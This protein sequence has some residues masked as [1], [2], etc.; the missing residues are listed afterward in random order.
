MSLQESHA[1]FSKSLTEQCLDAVYAVQSEVESGAFGSNQEAVTSA[2]TDAK[3]RSR[4][5][6]A[7]R[8]KLQKRM[9]DV[10]N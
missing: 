6:E 2:L 5:I 8:R 10:S 3:S 4:E 7:L 1:K 9:H